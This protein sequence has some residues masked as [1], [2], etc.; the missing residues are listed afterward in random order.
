MSG[1]NKKYPPT[2]LSDLEKAL[3]PLA[4]GIVRFHEGQEKLT[5]KMLQEDKAERDLKI[6]PKS[7]K[8]QW[9]KRND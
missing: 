6:M 4:R 7:M 9:R 3:S 2:F 5:E 8:K 1:S